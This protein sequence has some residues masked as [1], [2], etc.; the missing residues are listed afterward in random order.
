MADFKDLEIT[1]TNGVTVNIGDFQNIRPEYTLKAT[2][3]DGVN[4]SEIRA[5]FKK[6]IEAW[7]EDDI[8]EYG[9]QRIVNK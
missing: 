2:L 3:E 7:L 4:P 8:A 5:K 1:V 6:V 9:K